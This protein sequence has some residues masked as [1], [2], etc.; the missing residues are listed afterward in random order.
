MASLQQRAL[1]STCASLAVCL[2]YL[3]ATFASTLAPTTPTGF[4]IISSGSSPAIVP[5]EHHMTV[6]DHPVPLDVFETVFDLDKLPSISSKPLP[7]ILTSNSNTNMV[8]KATPRNASTDPLSAK[9]RF[10]SSSK[11]E[12]H[13]IISSS[14]S[15]DFVRDFMLFTCNS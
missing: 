2:S 9:M 4:K 10:L 15:A 1:P 14:A 3:G 11:P 8:S 7:T 13:T 6:D 5:T 12:Y